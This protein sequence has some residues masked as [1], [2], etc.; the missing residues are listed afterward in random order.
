VADTDLAER[1]RDASSRLAP[2]ERRVART[3][4][5]GYPMAGLETVATLAERAGTSPPTVLRLLSRLGFDGYPAFQRAIKAEL[6]E[7]LTSPVDLYPAAAVDGSLRRLP[8]GELEAAAKVLA[9]PRREIWTVGGRFSTVLAEYLALHLRLVRPGVHLVEADPG[10][11]AAA[12]L[13]IGRRSTVVAFDYQRYQR[14]TVDFGARA[15]GQ[16]AALVL[17]TDHL[18]SPLAAHADRV[19]ATTVRAGSPFDVLTPAMAVLETLVAAVRERLG[20]RPRKRLARHDALAADAVG[21]EG[22]GLSGSDA[23]T[24]DDAAGGGEPS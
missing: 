1:I 8:A 11:R 5:A 3:V 17:F 14:D 10:G 12:L 16:G 6:A 20:S 9:D 23:L 22:A 15:A 24:D 2:A 7:R 21:T 13:D 19:L 18:L 4:L